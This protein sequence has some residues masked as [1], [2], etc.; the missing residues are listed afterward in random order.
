MGTK[1]VL[2]IRCG[3]AA[4]GDSPDSDDFGAEVGRILRHAADMFEQGYAAVYLN[5][6]NGNPVGFVGL[7]LE[8]E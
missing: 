8:E 2:E 5:D 4:F 7:Q 1:L 6:S 3:N